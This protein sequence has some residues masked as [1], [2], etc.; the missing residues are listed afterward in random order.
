VQ[1]PL[2]AVPIFP[3]DGDDELLSYLI[4]PPTH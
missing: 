2:H 3:A 1:L 4:N